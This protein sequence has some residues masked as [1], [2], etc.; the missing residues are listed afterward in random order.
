MAIRTTHDKDRSSL[1]GDAASGGGGYGGGMDSREMSSYLRGPDVLRLQA[2]HWLLVDSYYTPEALAQ[3]IDILSSFLLDQSG[4]ISIARA[5]SGG[6]PRDG[7]VL[8]RL[9]AVLKRSL[10][11]DILI[12]G[13]EKVTNRRTH[14]LAHAEEEALQWR[15]RAERL[16]AYTNHHH[17]PQSSH[18]DHASSSDESNFFHLEANRILSDAG[19]IHDIMTPTHDIMTPIL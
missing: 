17:P 10:P 14:L 8:A 1:G 18:G 11:Y 9:H 6:S 4:G 19:D 15:D 13:T 12:T 3:A 7:T 16:P 5:P 2:L